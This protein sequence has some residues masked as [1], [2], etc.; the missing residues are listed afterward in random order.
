MR[1]YVTTVG[2]SPEAVFNPLWYLVEVHG[3][4]PD[5]VYLLWNDGVREQLEGVKG[6]IERL[7][8]AYGVGI[9]VIAGEDLRFSEDNPV[10]FR[11]RAASLIGSLVSEGHEVIAD[12]TPGRKFMSALLLGAAMARGAG[13]IT[14][15]HLEDWRRYAGK[16]LFEVPM[17][18]QRLFRKGELTG[19][20][21]KV[22]LPGR[23]RGPAESLTV[24]RESLMALLD[25]LYLDG[26]RRFRLAVRS[27]EIASVKL[28]RRARIRVR[29]YLTLDRELHGGHTM[30]KEAVIAGMGS[31]RNWDEL[32]EEVRALLRSGRPLYIGFDTNALLFR[33]PSRVIAE[34]DFYRN[35]NLI[36]DFAY[37]DEVQVEI[38]R[39]VNEKLP[40]DRELGPYSNQPTPRARLAS[41]GR[42]ELVKLREMGAERADSRRDERGDTKIA[43][44]YKAFAEEKDANV[45]VITLDDRAYAE[46]DALR[47]SGLVP[48]RLEWEFSFGEN[49]EGSWEALRDT[50]YTLAVTLGELN[51]HTYKL[52]GLWHGKNS[53]DWERERV[54]LNS[55]EYGRI[56]RVL[57]G[58]D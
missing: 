31:F 29:E 19:K 6:L 37:S 25:S 43:L 51:V 27:E 7:S 20:P 50:L 46:M 11:E 47:G 24:N 54:R 36:F 1:A 5:A 10:E 32:K 14:Y 40:F 44:D 56:F 12:I 3:W 13:E 21:G 35:G 8:S 23:K 41:I 55:F 26:L 58:G 42:V 33:V 30:V 2:T 9:N 16:L 28:G 34:G 4:V 39:Q 57:S 18:E 22:S 17:V 15:L 48:F 45:M 52:H 38:G 49:L 53:E